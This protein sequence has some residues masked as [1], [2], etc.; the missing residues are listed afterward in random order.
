LMLL[1]IAGCSSKNDSGGIVRSNSTEP[2]AFDIDDYDCHT[3]PLEYFCNCG[4]LAGT[5]TR[6]NLAG[7]TGSLDGFWITRTGDTI[8][9]FGGTFWRTTDGIGKF[10]GEISG[11]VTDEVWGDFDGNWVYDDYRMCPLCGSSHGKFQGHFRIF[12]SDEMGI[13]KGEFGDYSLPPD[14]NQ[15][16]LS[17][18]WIQY[19]SWLEESD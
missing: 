18:K 15:L 17:G 9:H 19:C 4:K 5:W 16:P 14:E 7:L 10:S 2:S 13:I 3:S 1:L 11:Y 12:N 8:G 6:D